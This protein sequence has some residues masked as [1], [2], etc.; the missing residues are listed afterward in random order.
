MYEHT[1]LRLVAGAELLVH[2]CEVY[3]IIG[4]WVSKPTGLCGRFVHSVGLCIQSEEVSQVLVQ[5]ACV[6]C[7]Y[8]WVC[9]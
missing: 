3:V 5:C 6:L 1:L 7:M 4:H 9:M 2:S 8:M